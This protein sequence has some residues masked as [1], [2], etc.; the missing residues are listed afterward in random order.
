MNSPN[1]CIV[2]L[3]EVLFRNIH[4]FIIDNY[5]VFF[6]FNDLF[7][8]VLIKDLYSFIKFVIKAKRFSKS[9]TDDM[10]TCLGL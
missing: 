7:I 6:N 3:S 9:T 5:D 10:W 8:K 1:H 2:I 4:T